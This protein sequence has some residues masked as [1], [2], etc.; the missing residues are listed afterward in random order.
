MGAWWCQ[1]LVLLRAWIEDGQGVIAHLGNPH[2]ALMVKRRAHQTTPGLWQRELREVTPGNNCCGRP[3]LLFYSWLT[4]GVIGD[5][6]TAYIAT[7]PQK[8]E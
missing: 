1:L 5:L 3:G 2:T 4:G 8:D 7:G 6:A